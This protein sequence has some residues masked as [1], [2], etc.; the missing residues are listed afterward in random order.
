MPRTESGPAICNCSR[1]DPADG[2]SPITRRDRRNARFINSISKPFRK[3]KTVGPATGVARSNLEPGKSAFDGE[4]RFDKGKFQK[5]EVKWQLPEYGCAL[6]QTKETDTSRGA[7]IAAT[8]E[9]A[10]A[11]G[12]V[13]AKSTAKFGSTSFEYLNRKAR[14]A[15]NLVAVT[16]GNAPPNL[17][18][19]FAAAIMKSKLFRDTILVRHNGRLLKHVFREW[20]GGKYPHRWDQAASCYLD[21]RIDGKASNSADLTWSQAAARMADEASGNLSTRPYRH[22]GRKCPLIF[23][24]KPFLCIFL[25]WLMAGLDAPLS[26]F[27]LYAAESPGREKKPGSYVPSNVYREGKA[28][29]DREGKAEVGKLV[30]LNE[31]LSANCLAQ[32]YREC[33]RQ[34]AQT[35]SRD[36]RPVAIE[37]RDKAIVTQW[38]AV[39]KKCRR[40]VPMA[41]RADAIQACMERLIETWNC[42]GSDA[43]GKFAD[44]AIDWEIQDFLKELRRQAPVQR[45]INLNDPADNPADSD[46]K[47]TLPER[48]DMM[49][50]NAMETQATTAKLRLVADRLDCLSLR[51]RRV[52]EGRLAL[53]G[54]KYPVSHEALAAELGMSERKV[55]RIERV[56]VEKL[57]QA[58]L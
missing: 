9:G 47:P 1:G 41:H 58:V 38:S 27:W 53:N 13:S 24:E 45:S 25:F 35:I 30:S 46:D 49:T 29:L 28:K 34:V 42:W 56:A 4:P 5:H 11:G 10:I 44:Q 48:P 36:K 57:R 8:W 55:A 52:I 19:F 50:F 54:Y 26:D 39:E 32:Y 43:F 7:S 22:E 33:W 40:L 17:G 37:A 2:H 15:G 31:L 23:Y 21:I 18:R 16:V 20:F 51:E 6:R 3:G 12:N 14:S